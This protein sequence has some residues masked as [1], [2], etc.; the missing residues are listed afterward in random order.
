M[1]SVFRKAAGAD[2]GDVGVDGGGC[3]DG[4]DR[5]GDCGDARV[6]E[7]PD[8]A[9]GQP[10]WAAEPGEY[11]DWGNCGDGEFGAGADDACYCREC[12]GH[13]CGVGYGGVV[14]DCTAS[15]RGFEAGAGGEEQYVEQDLRSSCE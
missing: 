6:T 8:D 4:S 1:G 11:C 9:S 5:C 13:R 7:L 3:D 15:E 2:G 10:G 14:V 12:D